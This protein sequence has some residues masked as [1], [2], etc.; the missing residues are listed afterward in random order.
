MTTENKQHNW[1]EAWHAW[2]RPQI[3]TLLFLGF[4]AGIPILLIWWL[5]S[6][7]A[8][9]GSVDR[10]PF[11]SQ[12]GNQ[13]YYLSYRFFHSIA[14]IFTGSLGVCLLTPLFAKQFLEKAETKGPL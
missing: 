3:I 10:S 13:G 8:D 7:G 2:T 11:W 5:I 1:Y 14:I 9:P 12:V 4:S 6:T